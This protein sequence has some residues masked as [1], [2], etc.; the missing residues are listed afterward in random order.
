MVLRKLEGLHG[1]LIVV[2]HGLLCASFVR[3]HATFGEGMVAPAH[4]TNASL[5][6]IERDPPFRIQLLNDAAHL[7]DLNIIGA[8]V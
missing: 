2:S 3:G 1:N 7:A 4:F 6:T 8:A 5:T